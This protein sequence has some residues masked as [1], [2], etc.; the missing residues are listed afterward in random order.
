MY[1][2]KEEVFS[3]SYTHIDETVRLTGSSLR[4]GCGFVCLPFVFPEEVD[5]S[6]SDFAQ[7]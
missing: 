6:P 3:L 4:K 5:S 7:Y 1:Y 2:L